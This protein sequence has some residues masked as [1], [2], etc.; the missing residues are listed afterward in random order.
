[1][2]ALAARNIFISERE[3][4]YLGCKFI[5]YLALAH[6]QSRPVLREF[7][8]RKGGYIPHVDG[9]CEGDIPNLFCGLDGISELVLDTVKIAS[10]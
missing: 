5:I 3:I 1:M 2:A 10:E 8:M 6:R 9:I 7:L 4:S